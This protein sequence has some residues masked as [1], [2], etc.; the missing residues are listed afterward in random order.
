M[1]F[2]PQIPNTEQAPTRAVH[3]DRPLERQGA[4]G[5]SPAWQR[6]PRLETPS[7]TSRAGAGESAERM[8]PFPY[9]ADARGVAQR[10]NTQR[11]LKNTIP[12][13][14]PSPRFVFSKSVF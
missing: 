11:M 7:V 2:G 14:G 3:R 5:L 10:P 1:Q 9:A 12:V 13:K 4:L 6:Q 8:P